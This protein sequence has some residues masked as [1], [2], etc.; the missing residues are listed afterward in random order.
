[1]SEQAKVT[2][3]FTDKKGRVSLDSVDHARYILRNAR[4]WWDK[5]VVGERTL[6]YYSDRPISK[7]Y[8]EEILKT[9]RFLQIAG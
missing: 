2:I 4:K 3:I 5:I 7:K 1:M 9:G 6:F 8:I